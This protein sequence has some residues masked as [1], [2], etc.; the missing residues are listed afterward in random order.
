VANARVIAGAVIAVLLCAAAGAQQPRCSGWELVNPQPQA[1]HLRDV[2]FG[3]GRW[4]AVGEGVAVASA[5]AA[6][7]SAVPLPGLALRG[8]AYGNDA[9]VAVGGGGAVVRSVDGV[10]WEDVATPAAADLQGVA[11]AGGAFLAVGADA[12]V[13][14]SSDGLS[15]TQERPDAVQGDLAG[16]GVSGSLA[17][18]QGP[19]F[20]VWGTSSIALRRLDGTWL[21]IPLPGGAVVTRGAFW[22]NSSICVTMRC[23]TGYWCSDWSTGFFVTHDGATWESLDYGLNTGP[24]DVAVKEKGLVGLVD[25]ELGSVTALYTTPDGWSWFPRESAFNVRLRTLVAG[26]GRFVAVGDFGAIFTSADGVTWSSVVGPTA[27]L[28]RIAWNEQAFA[29]NASGRGTNAQGWEIG[30][31]SQV[32]SGDGRDWS[33]AAAGD[34]DVVTARPGQFLGVRAREVHASADGLAWER[35]PDLPT[36]GAPGALWDGTRFVILTFQNPPNCPVTCPPNPVLAAVSEDLA[37]WVAVEQPDL[38]GLGRSLLAGMAFD[39]RRYVAAAGVNP[40]VSEPSTGRYPVFTSADGLSWGSLPEIMPGTKEGTS[41]IATNGSGFVAVRGTS[42]LTSPDGLA[43]SSA[44]IAPL[45]LIGAMWTGDE[46]VAVGDDG[47]GRAAIARSPDGVSWTPETFP[48]IP[49]RLLAVT[50]GRRVQLAVGAAGLTL[51]REC[52]PQSPSRRLRGSR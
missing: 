4:V 51:R 7:W 8:V 29:A 23:D 22:V 46:Y 48:A 47:G 30:I 24:S 40:T 39:G 14:A 5:D 38:L 21:A 3:G 41:A 27:E 45:H 35:K 49:A 42:V 17:G 26:G 33:P 9:F 32:A 37:S 16:V 50:G 25:Y 28:Y 12:T 6:A 13:L 15:W 2:A 52:H 10:T 44:G 31:R 36:W 34:I 1:N 20:L 43:W 19:M 11:F 18:N